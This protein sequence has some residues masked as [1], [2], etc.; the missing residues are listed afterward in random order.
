MLSGFM[1]GRKMSEQVTA[2]A[3]TVVLYDTIKG[4]LKPMFPALAL[5]EYEAEMMGL[6]YQGV[7]QFSPDVGQITDETQAGDIGAYTDELGVY[8]YDA[9]AY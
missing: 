7:A 4:F 2:G 1:V 5:A 3:V 6:G 8:T 9:P